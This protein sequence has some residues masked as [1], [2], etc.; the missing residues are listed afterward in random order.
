VALLLP[1]TY[2]GFGFTPLEAMARG[3]PVLASDIPALREIAGDGAHLLP[4]HAEER[5]REA[6]EQ[7]AGDAAFREGLR[8]RGTATVARYSWD[9]TARGVL[10][11]FGALALA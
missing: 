1:S 7:V 3:C 2:E 10:E 4:P 5:W 11:L 8:A 9:S 6:I